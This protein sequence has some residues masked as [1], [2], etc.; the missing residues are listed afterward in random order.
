M[1]KRLQRA[2]IFWEA[3]LTAIPNVFLVRFISRSRCDLKSHSS[4]KK[5][6]RRGTDKTH[7]KA[8]TEI[9]GMWWSW[10][11]SWDVPVS[12]GGGSEVYYCPTHIWFHTGYFQTFC[13]KNNFMWHNWVLSVQKEN[14]A[15]SLRIAH[16]RPRPSVNLSFQLT[17]SVAE[18]LILLCFCLSLYI[19]LGLF[20]SGLTISSLGFTA[21]GSQA[22]CLYSTQ[23]SLVPSIFR[24]MVMAQ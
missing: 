1:G 8:Y 17:T 14:M 22:L 18:S 12:V 21:L 13:W 7:L 24:V 11:G 2:H 15:W 19:C 4:Q 3:V 6:P 5:W 23:C 20:F 9:A 16:M 10:E